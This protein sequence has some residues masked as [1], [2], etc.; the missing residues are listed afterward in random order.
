M[1]MMP[2]ICE[3]CGTMFPSGIVIENSYNITFSGNRAGPCPQCGGMGAIPDGVYDFIG[4]TIKVLA[5]SHRSV[6]D[7][8]R[9]RT[10]VRDA[11]RDHRPI[12]EVTQAIK[13]EDPELGSV[14]ERLVLPRNAG[15]FYAFL[16][17]L[18]A[19]ITLILT[20][21]QQPAATTNVDIDINQHIDKVVE[22]CWE[23]DP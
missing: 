4:D 21:R 8:R 22:N 19:T 23:K 3:T 14:I 20:M 17:F 13:D 11:R 1:P 5:G 9:L 15:E 6:E 16:A 12:T 2:A 7:L 18:V 10:I